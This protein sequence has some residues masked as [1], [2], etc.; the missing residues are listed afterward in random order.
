MK[1]GVGVGVRAVMHQ[2][3]SLMRNRLHLPGSEMIAI[4]GGRTGLSRRRGA[5]LGGGC[6]RGVGCG[7]GADREG[8]GAL[9]GSSKG[10]GVGC[11][12]GVGREGNGALKGCSKGK[13]QGRRLGAE[14]AADREGSM[15]GKVGFGRD[16]GKGNGWAG[17]D[18]APG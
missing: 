10:K 12:T 15:I 6:G 18:G 13:G 17:V 8:A 11:G 5:G 9:K 4:G 3:R 1:N 2:W 14:Q 16:C 7:T